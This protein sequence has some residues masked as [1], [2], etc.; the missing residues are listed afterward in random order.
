VLVPLDAPLVH[1]GGVN[2][3]RVVEHLDGGS[4]VIMSWALN[5]H[6]FVNFAAQQDGRIR[7]RYSLTSMAGRLDAAQA[8]RFSAEVRTPPVVLRD[9]RLFSPPSGAVCRVVEGSDLI[10]G[11]KVSE[12]G[13]GVVIR[14]LNGKSADERVTIDLGRPLR[15]AWTVLPDERE[16]APVQTEGPT[17]NLVVGP[18]CSKSLLLKW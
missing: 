15:G 8:T 4:P 14:L 12:D 17:V 6:W 13:S 18:R 7:L 16:E 11:S 10:V 9:R 1:L 3:G 2:T 5:N